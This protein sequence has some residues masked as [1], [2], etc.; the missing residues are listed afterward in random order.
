M[1]GHILQSLVHQKAH[2]QW[3]IQKLKLSLIR[4]FVFEHLDE[5]FRSLQYLLSTI[6][7]LGICQVSLE[8]CDHL[9]Q[10]FHVPDVA[11]AEQ[12]VFQRSHTVKLV[13]QILADTTLKNGQTGAMK[14]VVLPNCNTC[15]SR[16][17]IGNK[18]SC[19]R[20]STQSSN[21]R[22]CNQLGQVTN[23][24]AQPLLGPLDFF[25]QSLL[26]GVNFFV[27]CVQTRVYCIESRDQRA[28]RRLKQLSECFQVHLP[29]L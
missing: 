5:I 8:L 21:T 7:L 16:Q 20:L 2:T 26:G 6:I 27:Q 23:V 10:Q 13:I 22:S 9:F 11:L 25:Q 17:R 29:F 19:I 3:A 28:E 1:L 4:S 12:K 15:Q 18:L 14:P 24:M